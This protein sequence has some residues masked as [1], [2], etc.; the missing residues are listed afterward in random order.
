MQGKR[1]LIVDDDLHL[2]DLMTH[3]FGRRQARV[4]TAAD[5]AEGLRQFYA[6]RPDLVLLDLMMPNVDGWQVCRQIRQR[7]G[8]PVIMLSA[9]D[10]NEHVVRGLDCGADDYI[11]KPFSM[12]VLLARIRA[13]LRRSALTNP[14][15]QYRPFSDD[16]L[17]VDLERRRVLAGGEPVRLSP[18]EY[19]LLAYLVEH[20]DQ[21]V[22]FRRILEAVWGSAYHDCVDHVYVYISRL[23]Q[24]LEPDPANPRYLLTEHGVGYRFEKQERIVPPGS[25]VVGT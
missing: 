24:K 8:V 16:H 18:T 19:G 15:E 1:I 17:T 22:T 7:S 10:R 14:A 5:G 3:I 4:Y 25:G 13:A 21:A 2:L 20:A 9:L 12:E 11:T 23:R 6:H